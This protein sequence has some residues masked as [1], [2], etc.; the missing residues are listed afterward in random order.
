MIP[1][2]IHYCWFGRGEKPQL[3]KKC[4]E[5]WK[6]F[7]PDFEIKEWNEDNY[8]VKSHPYT[9]FCYNN[10]KWAFLSD[11]VRLDV[12][13]RFG[14]IYLDTDVEMVRS[15]EPLLQ[16]HAFYGFENERYIATG[17]GF[18]AEP[19]H[20]TVSALKKEYECFESQD[21]LVQ[22]TGCPVLN[23]N[24]LLEFGLL[25]N[26]CCQRVGEAEI[27]PVEYFNPYED[28]TGKLNVTENTF[29]IHWYAKSALPTSAKI[30][31]R[32][33]RPFHRAFGKDCFK[34]IKSK[35]K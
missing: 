30:R 19:G 13:E 8:D 4:I 34:K 16:F 1:K 27:F 31:S 11:F 12:V 3:A 9:E 23:T 21:S 17:L 20:M 6:K 18:G 35:E 14:G 22:L 24:A 15:F 7:C 26:G 2:I 25:R 33:T 5:S 32:L 10:K 29:S 28:S